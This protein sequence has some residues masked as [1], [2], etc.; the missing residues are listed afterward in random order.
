MEMEPVLLTFMQKKGD[1]CQENLK[2]IKQ[3]AVFTIGSVY[4][5]VCLAV[6]PWQS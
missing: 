6:C 4:V 5:S 3:N 2:S 1:I